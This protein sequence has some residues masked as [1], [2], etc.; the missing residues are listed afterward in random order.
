MPQRNTRRKTCG[1]PRKKIRW[2]RARA[3][4]RRRVTIYPSAL[5]LGELKGRHRS[6][7]LFLH[8]FDKGIRCRVY[9]LPDGSLQIKAH[10]GRMWRMSDD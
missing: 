10:W 3:L 4:G 5:L 1:E 6:G 7:G 2:R 9:G 8:S